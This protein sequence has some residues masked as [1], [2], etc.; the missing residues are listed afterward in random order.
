MALAYVARRLAYLY[1][2]PTLDHQLK[3][4]TGSPVLYSKVFPTKS[5]SLMQRPKVIF[6]DAVGTCLA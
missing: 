3:V 5:E 1:R 4:L 6:L 2:M